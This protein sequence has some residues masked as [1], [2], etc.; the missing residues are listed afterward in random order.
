MLTR[1]VRCSER[2]AN[3]T[4]RDLILMVDSETE[5]LT[6]WRVGS[7]GKCRPEVLK[8]KRSSVQGQKPGSVNARVAHK[9]S[10]LFI[11]VSDCTHTRCLCSG[12]S[13]VQRPKA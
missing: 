6:C 7:F 12:P 5:D 13:I 4:K 8:F 9:Y 1:R 2:H 11:T 10:N 3:L